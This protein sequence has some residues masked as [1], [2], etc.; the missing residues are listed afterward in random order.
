MDYVW[1]IVGLALVAIGAEFLV[2]GAVGLASHYRVSPLL[3][4][5]TIVAWGTSAPELVVGLNAAFRGSTG[6][7]VGNAVGSNIFNIVA[8]VGIAAIVRPIPSPRRETIVRDGTI[9]VIAAASLLAFTWWRREIDAVAGIAFLAT[10]TAYTLFV[11][12]QARLRRVRSARVA[13]AEELEKK[14]RW[15]V[16]AGVLSVVAGLGG[17]V[18][19]AALLVESGSALARSWGVSETV[20]G[21]TLIAGGTSLPE[22]ATSAVATLRRHG[23][24]AIG[25]VL[26]SNIYNI[27]GILGASALVRPL[28][29]PPRIMSFDLPV[30]LAASV[31]VLT[32]WIVQ[33]HVGR[34]A[35]LVLILAFAV[36]LFATFSHWV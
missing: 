11:F 28:P 22:L 7:A 32:L 35:G 31:F 20:I 27:L 25:N 23:E 2:R 10:L 36:Y 18:Y 15:T 33:K 1:L 34:K 12:L 21:L 9:G 19:G 5:L 16:V 29:V 24:I 14:V 17:L 30:L 13:V 4:G 8:I 3:V 6:L 26:G